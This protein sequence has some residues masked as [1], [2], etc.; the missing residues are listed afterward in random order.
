MTPSIAAVAAAAALLL[1]LSLPPLAAAQEPLDL[2]SL[3]EPLVLS[4]R[5]G[6]FGLLDGVLGL[7]GP[8]E[9][10][11]VPLDEIC[12]GLGLALEVDAA[13]GRVEGF[14][15]KEE[16][17]FLLDLARGVVESA[18]QRYEIPEGAVV[19]A[20]LELYVDL[21][22][23]EGWLEGVRLIYH[24]SS[25]AVEVESDP[26]LPALARLG[27]QGER[28]R[29]SKTEADRPQRELPAAVAAYRL[30]SPPILDVDSSVQWSSGQQPSAS[31]GVR[32]AQDLAGMGARW[33][34][35]F[36]RE[37]KLRETRFTLRRK[38]PGGGL[39]GRLA[40]TELEIGDVT[41]FGAP[42]LGG[43]SRGAGLRFTNRPRE[44]SRGADLDLRGELPAGWEAELY[45]G[46]ALLAFDV[47]AEGGEYHFDDVPLFPGVNELRVVRHGPQG[48]RDEVRRTVRLG[49][50]QPAPGR[51][52]FDTSVLLQE[53]PTLSLAARMEEGS[54]S[55]GR[56]ADRGKLAAE[57]RFVL[58]LKP[59]LSLAGSLS[60]LSLEGRRRA[61][62]GLSTELFAGPFRLVIDGA[63]DE[64]GNWGAGG[65]AVANL[66]GLG[67]FL[68][69]QEFA[70]RFRSPASSRNG[71]V[72]QKSELRLRHS[73]NLPLLPRSVQT[74]LRARYENKDGGPAR[75]AIRLGAST[76]A[77]PWRFQN[78]ISGDW[79]K[80]TEGGWRHGTIGGA[81]GIEIRRRIGNLRVGFDYTLAPRWDLRSLKL[82]GRQ[83]FL[84]G[85]LQVNPTLQ[86][87]MGG[88]TSLGVGL[89]WKLPMAEVSA[90]VNTDTAGGLSAS[91][92][93]RFSM[94][95][96][97]GR[98]LPT[99]NGRSQTGRSL[100]HVEVFLDEDHDGR[101]SPGDQ[102]LA[103]VRVQP[104]NR[105]ELTDERGFLA[106]SGLSELVPTDVLLDPTSLE[107]PFLRPG[108]PGYRV[109][110]RPGAPLTLMFPVIRVSDV[111][112]MVLLTE[113]TADADGKAT[114]PRTR[115][116][117]NVEIVF[118]DGQGRE[119]ARRRSES[120]GFFFL[121]GLPAGTYTVCMDAAQMTRHG[122][123]DGGGIRITVEAD[124]ALLSGLELHLRP[125][126]SRSE[127]SQ[128]GLL[129]KASF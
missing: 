20:D 31:L 13:G 90:Q 43:A 19:A 88:E 74:T 17:G 87:Q 58:G 97:A 99:L 72:R 109:S 49:G 82:S 94:S 104:G 65:R 9:E 73:L 40:G 14:Y 85:D 112:G 108:V 46:D 67:I 10:V 4:F 129:P 106:L 63:V 102:G 5:Q 48:Q 26:P 57:A 68:Q 54:R 69:H 81:L 12:R 23:L 79:T 18:G 75:A 77:G 36:D 92:G 120:D 76:S 122:L 114:G 15:L 44:I 32:G 30:V 118:I 24:P 27:R 25:L 60:T 39:L 1:S 128:D 47:E 38:D 93:L 56:D 52:F 11:Y 53:R 84:D 21:K 86:H 80:A 35:G 37:M 34:L 29:V 83:S 70:P 126:K 78:E 2:F 91:F 64:E 111:E 110:A 98:F 42:L 28:N 16:N 101:R 8:N 125:A 105:H 127:R 116:L 59:G 45:R 121:P 124:A 117:G 71:P 66:G 3:G 107:D 62:A 119:V 22:A 61:Y 96:R 103:G 7:L 115:G 6:R 33:F 123:E 100:A 113:E 41:A 51:W 50:D 95:W 89:G 55:S